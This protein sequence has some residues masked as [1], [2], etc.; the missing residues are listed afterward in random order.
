MQRI[1]QGNE[2]STT[3]SAIKNDTGGRQGAA[4]AFDLHWHPSTSYK[5][6]LWFDFRQRE[7][8]EGDER[9]EMDRCGEK[10]G[11]G[12]EEMSDRIKEREG[13]HDLALAKTQGLNL[14]L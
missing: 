8:K 10:G 1:I 7:G 13:A 14:V 12:S 2:G 6:V 11:G 4:H 5:F 9:K 3:R